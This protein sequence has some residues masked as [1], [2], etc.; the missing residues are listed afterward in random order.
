MVTTAQG[1]FVGKEE[2]DLWGTLWYA[3]VEGVDRKKGPTKR[4]EEWALGL[5]EPKGRK[6]FRKK[7]EFSS[8]EGDQEV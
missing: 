6:C 7:E 2:C 8:I 1:E 4:S 3:H 5:S